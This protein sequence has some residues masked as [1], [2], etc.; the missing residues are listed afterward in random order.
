[1]TQASSPQRL[2]ITNHAPQPLTT[3]LLIVE[4]GLYEL[5]DLSLGRT[6]EVDLSQPPLPFPVWRRQKPRED[7]SLLRAALSGRELRGNILLV[8]RALPQRAALQGAA[9][10]PSLA[11]LVLVS[12]SRPPI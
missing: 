5:P 2:S 11:P 6:L 7:L 10:E 3:V 9:E 8:G 1:M 12:A 4:E